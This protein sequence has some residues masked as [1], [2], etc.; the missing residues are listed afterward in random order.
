MD[1]LMV[2]CWLEIAKQ[3]NATHLMIV[4]DVM[5]HDTF[6]V[7]IY[8]NMDVNFTHSEYQTG[9][10]RVLEI[11]NMNINIDEQYKSIR[12]FNL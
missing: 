2:S 5:E 12:A 4:L 8:Q 11:Y 10:L 6:P 9:L 3:E 7:Y 1:K